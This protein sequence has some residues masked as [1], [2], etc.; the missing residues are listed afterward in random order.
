[1]NGVDP[2]PQDVAI[3]M[4]LF[5]DH[6]VKAFVYNEQVTDSFT[7][8]LLALAHQDHIPVVGVYETMPT[9]EYDYQVLDGRR[10]ARALDDAAGPRHLVPQA[11]I[12]RRTPP[13]TTTR[14]CRSRGS[15]VWLGGRADPRRRRVSPCNGDSSPA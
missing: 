1:M 2:A 7:Q 14:S 6:V 13:I 8:S 4:G 15:S 5:S 11:V 12:P 10:G 9:P 3:E